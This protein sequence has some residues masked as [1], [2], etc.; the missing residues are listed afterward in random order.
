VPRNIDH[1]NFQNVS[2]AEAVER[3]DAADIG[4]V[5]IRPS[6][7]GT[8]NIDCSIKVYDGVVSNINIKETKKDSGV[9]NLGLGTPLIID[10]EEYEDLDEVMARHIE[11]IVSNVKHMLK[12]RKFMR[13]SAED[14]DNALKQQLARNPGIR[15]YALGVVE[16]RVNKGMVLFCISFIMSSSGRVHHE[17]IK[18]IPAGFYYRKMEFPSVD[19]MLAYFK[20]NCSKP[21]PGARDMDNG[22]WN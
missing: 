15:P 9:G 5:I 13:G 8:K 18:V 17:Y 10:D 7:R 14:I 16:Q 11:P 2:W 6:G 20:V 4:E 21:P 12:H 3:L 1:P 19:R 22:G